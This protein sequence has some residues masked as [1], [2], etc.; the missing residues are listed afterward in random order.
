MVG[1]HA[2]HPPASARNGGPLLIALDRYASCD[3][4]SESFDHPEHGLVG[5]HIIYRPL[6]APAVTAVSTRLKSRL[7]CTTALR[8]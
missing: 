3:T 4:V 5:L 2:S 1:T 6:R 8:S 7:I